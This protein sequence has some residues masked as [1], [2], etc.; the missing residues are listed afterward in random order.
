MRNDNVRFC[1]KMDLIP[2]DILLEILIKLDLEPFLKMICTCKKVA[3]IGKCDLLW[4]RKYDEFPYNIGNTINDSNCPKERYLRK[5]KPISEIKSWIASPSFI[6]HILSFKYQ[7]QYQTDAII[8]S[9]EQFILI[10]PQFNGSYPI[11]ALYS[12][13]ISYQKPNMYEY[14]TG[15]AKYLPIIASNPLK[16]TTSS[17]FIRFERKTIENLFQKGEACECVERYK[18][19]NA[20]YTRDTGSGYGYYNNKMYLISKGDFYRLVNSL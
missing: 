4:Q 7:R 8:F 14:A 9:D 1:K 5:Y 13:M 2:R 18:F 6:S 12:D 3:Q 15:D 16:I 10:K 19:N 11:L 17:L 20:S